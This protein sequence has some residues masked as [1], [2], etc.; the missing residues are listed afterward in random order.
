MH[1][2]N[3]CIVTAVLLLAAAP[4]VAVHALV[5]A[6]DSYRVREELNEALHTAATHYQSNASLYSAQQRSAKIKEE[7]QQKL[8][9]LARKKREL[10]LQLSSAQHVL[11]EFQ[12]RNGID[13]GDAEHM[14][15]LVEQGEKEL[16]AFVRTL[17]LRGIT[18]DTSG[19]VGLLRQY[20]SG[21][22]SERTEETMRNRA[23]V[24][25]RARLIGMV[26]TARQYRELES[27]LR[28]AYENAQ[29]E[30][31]AVLRQEEIA[32]RT[33]HASASR[34]AQIQSIVQEVQDQILAMQSELARIDARLRR[35]AERT[36][37]EKGLLSGR[38]G[39]YT[40]GTVVRDGEKLSWPVYGRIS[41]GFMDSSYRQYFGVDHRAIDIVVPQGTAVRSAADGVVFLARDGG[42]TGYS[43]ILIGHR[44][45]RA[46]LYG[47]LSEIGVITGQDVVSGQ[48]I[49]RSGGEPG[50]YGAGPM[51]TGAHLH[52]EVV[53]SGVHVNPLQDLPS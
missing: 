4:L 7:T 23:L 45:G 41:A 53:H 52:F 5:A 44:G 33:L 47:H 43:Y 29:E 22:L 9:V 11:S 16:S 25:S 12:E 27:A 28:T 21:S 36:L 37:I 39:A 34:Q 18:E 14:K 42:Q 24:R 6:D 26:A 3:R 46:T 17:H 15:E 32:D 8:P 2:L 20:L 10:R 30:Y 1:T 31:L 40:D 48:V 38:E 19:G 50:S 35:S 51:T 49:G 13:P